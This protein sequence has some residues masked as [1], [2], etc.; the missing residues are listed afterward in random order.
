MASLVSSYRVDTGVK[1]S[2]WLR[3]SFSVSKHHCDVVAR[4]QQVDVQLVL[5]LGPTVM[6]FG[7]ARN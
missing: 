7:L 6:L 3:P 5:R 2:R 1:S 4:T